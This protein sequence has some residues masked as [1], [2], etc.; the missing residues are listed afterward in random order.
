[1]VDSVAYIDF[2]MTSQTP[3][4]LS[5]TEKAKERGYFEDGA[6]EEPAT[7]SGVCEEF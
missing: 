3:K 7:Y 1:M 6:D 5:T 4:E 2:S